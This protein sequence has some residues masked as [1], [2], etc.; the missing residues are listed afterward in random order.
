MMCE[1]IGWLA[2]SQRIEAAVRAAIREGQTSADLGGSLSTRELGDWLTR[3]LM[4]S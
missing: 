4:A 1:S 2:E 3:K